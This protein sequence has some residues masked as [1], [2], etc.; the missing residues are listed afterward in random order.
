MP[1]RG[2][3]RATQSQRF[4][5][6]VSQPIPAVALAE[7]EQLNHLP[8]ACLWAVKLA[9]SVPQTVE[10]LRPAPALAQLLERA[11]SC[12][13]AR[14]PS[15]HVE[16]V[17]Q[18]EHLLIAREIAF[19]PRHALPLLPNLEIGRQQLHVRVPA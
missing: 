9:E 14:L 2:R 1:H 16:I 17:L 19:V 10:I 13:R 7:P 11:R 18:I 5:D 4:F 3:I 12:Q 8:R 6:G 15:Q